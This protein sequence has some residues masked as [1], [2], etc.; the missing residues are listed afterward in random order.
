MPPPQATG[1]PL[2]DNRVSVS[3]PVPHSTLDWAHVGH[4]C[5]PRAFECGTPPDPLNHI[6]SRRPDLYGRGLGT[7][8]P[9]CSPRCHLLL[10]KAIVPIRGQAY[11][12]TIV[13]L[14]LIL[15]SGEE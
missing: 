11:T 2:I 3:F 5:G 12:T 14:C 1:C 4:R 13:R 8:E 10:K 7:T 15:N 6:H 9:P